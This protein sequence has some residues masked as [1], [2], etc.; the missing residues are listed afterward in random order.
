MRPISKKPR[1]SFRR[2][3]TRTT[4]RAN[5]NLANVILAGKGVPVDQK[6]ALELLREAA[7]AGDSRAIGEIGYCYSTGVGV[8]LDYPTAFQYFTKAS[9]RGNAEASGNLGVLYMNGRA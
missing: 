6:R 9:D 2:R 4:S 7:D 3:W 1:N 8:K 5:T